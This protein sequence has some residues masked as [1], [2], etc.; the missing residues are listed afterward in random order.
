M[1]EVSENKKLQL[2]F[3]IQKKNKIYLKVITCYGKTL[4]DPCR[5]RISKP[6]TAKVDA[7]QMTQ[8]T[9]QTELISIFEK[10]VLWYIFRYK[11]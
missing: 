2:V 11:L 10:N 6:R 8:N 9:H 5:Q 1:F 3:R 7:A 4:V